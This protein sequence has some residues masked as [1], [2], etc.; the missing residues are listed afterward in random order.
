[1]KKTDLILAD[2]LLSHQIDLLRFTAGERKKVLALLTGLQKELRVKLLSELTDFGKARVNKVL[3][4]AG[5]V[6]DRYY[7]AMAPTKKALDPFV[8]EARKYESLSKFIDSFDLGDE[9][10]IITV[11]YRYGKAPPSGLSYNSMTQS[12]EKGVS[13]ASAGGQKEIGS[14]AVSGARRRGKYFYKLEAVDTGGDDEVIGKIIKEISEKEY[15][16]F[17]ASS[18]NLQAQMTMAQNQLY[19]KKRL[20]AK[21]YS[22][23]AK[24]IK[25]WEG[26]IAEAEKKI[27][28]IW[29]ETALSRKGTDLLALASHEAAFTASTISAIGLDAA[30]P[31]EAALKALVNG[32]LIEGAPSAAWWAK[33]S[34][35]LQFKFAAQVRQGIAQGETLQQII[36]RVA[37]SKKLGL[38]GIFDVSRRN[39]SALVHTSIQQVANDARLATFKA[40]DD[41]IKGVRQLSTL[42]SHT[43]TVCVS[44]SG[45]SWDLE[46]NPINGTILPFNGGT[47]RHW[48]AVA[49]GEMVTTSRGAK[50]IDAVMVGDHVLTHRNRFKPVTAV[51]SKSNESGFIR[52]I[53]TKSGGV[54]RVTDEHPV[55]TAGRGWLRADMLKAGDELLE[56]RNEAMPINIGLPVAKRNTDDNPSAR[57]AF[58]ILSAIGSFPGV[59]S[60]PVNFND[61]PP[62]GECKITDRAPFNKLAFM[63]NSERRQIN[64]E[65]GLAKW[66]IF[67]VAGLDLFHN[68]FNRAWERCRV[69]LLHALRVCGIH[70]MSFFPQTIGPMV[71][72][73]TNPGGLQFGHVFPGSLT[74]GSGFNTVPFTPSLN[75]S[76]TNS[77]IPFNGA[78]GFPHNEMLFFDES[79]ERDLV[80]EINHFNTSIISD[81]KTVAYNGR[82]VNIEVDED[83]TFLVDGIIVHNCR[84][85]LVPITMT[86]RELGIDIPDMPPGTRASDL[87][88]I[89]ADTSFDSFLKRHDAAYV[90]DLLGKGR[91]DLWRKGTITL[92]DLLGQTGRPLTLAQL[93]ERA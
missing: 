70:W 88:E 54:I 24:E 19:R 78:K 11:G 61:D 89:P 85:V 9:G 71:F 18:E 69:V 40:N 38:S 80:S 47:P 59:M 36:I 58:R 37:G 65:K 32:S 55:L 66:G 22:I 72:P 93:R 83:Q 25:Y 20:I 53:N 64:R 35:D 50:P 57:G 29:E 42:D 28:L 5:E 7:G 90:D 91:A 30:L 92:Q 26:Q 74:L 33:Q 44:Y 12:Y 14:F 13:F 87:G 52:I 77:E 49:Y 8:M 6:I 1:M 73:G 23:D 86:Y 56:H 10:K 43:S 31:S 4:E 3:K 34:D 17:L 81:I 76:F 68:A 46:G 21:G 45:A 16:A 48:N 41:I 60:A 82:V 79:F 51:M 75:H 67:K 62:G 63:G 84:S 2:K 39:A 15:N 27:T